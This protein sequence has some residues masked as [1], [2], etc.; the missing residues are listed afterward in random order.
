MLAAPDRVNDITD[1]LNRV[2]RGERVDHYETQRKS[3]DGR[4][5]TVALSVSPIHD[6]AGRVIAAAKVVRDITDQKRLSQLQ[7]RLAA[8]VESS[9]D[10]IVSKDLTGHIQSWNRAPSSCLAT[11]PMR[12]S[13]SPSP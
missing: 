9:G 10:A 6:A 8:I 7:E 3:K 5:L 4:I 11:P 1:I 13:V 2:A 12:S